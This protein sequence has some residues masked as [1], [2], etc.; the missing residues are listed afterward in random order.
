MYECGASCNTVYANPVKCYR[1]L[2]HARESLGK[3]SL[4]SCIK[5]K[6]RHLSVL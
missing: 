4:G 1:Y 5:P 6:S 3:Y 2:W